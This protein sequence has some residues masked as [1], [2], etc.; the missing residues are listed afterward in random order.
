MKVLHIT[1]N[2]P[3]EEFPIFGIFVKEQVDSLTKIGVDNE[4]FF[5]DGKKKGFKQYITYVP[6]IFWKVLTNKYDVIHCHHIISG[7]LLCMT[8]IPLIKKCVLSYQGDPDWEWGRFFFICLYPFFRRIIIKNTSKYLKYKKTVYLPNGVNSDF[9]RPIDKSLCRKKLKWGDG[10]YILFFDSYKTARKVKRLDRLES[11]VEILKQKHHEI[12]IIPIVLRNVEREQIP[13][14]INASD[15]HLLCSDFE[16]SPN[17][18]KE[19]ICCN[20]PVVSTN[21]GNVMEMIG[22]IEGCY[23]SE[24]FDNNELAVCV[25]KVMNSDLIFNGRNALLA[26]GYGIDDTAK[27]LQNIYK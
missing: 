5:A 17:S 21:V 6:K 13:I 26:K 24:K 25:E 9:F 23:I 1:T 18:V 16:G 15:L 14:Y 19:C 3:T 4:V 10:F 12:N 22:D 7:I 27:R 20:T 8:G 2:Y 11:V